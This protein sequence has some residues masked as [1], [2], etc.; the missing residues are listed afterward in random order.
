MFSYIPLVLSVT[1]A[2]WM[3]SLCCCQYSLAHLLSAAFYSWQLLSTWKDFLLVF[4]RG[5]MLC[6]DNRSHLNGLGFKPVIV[7][8]GLSPKGSKG[9][10]LNSLFN[11]FNNLGKFFNFLWML[12]LGGADVRLSFLFGPVE[13]FV[14]ICT[15]ACAGEMHKLDNDDKVGTNALSEDISITPCVVALFGSRI[16]LHRG[17]GRNKVPAGAAHSRWFNNSKTS[18]VS[19]HDWYTLFHSFVRR[20]YSLSS[21]ECLAH[22]FQDG[23]IYL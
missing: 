11:I 12:Y 8:W 10:F 22:F 14:I 18:K 1:T 19:S 20:R 15:I 9:C 3:L 6:F 2:V 17:H 21:W 23:Y 4:S 16:W 7:L 5:S 13:L